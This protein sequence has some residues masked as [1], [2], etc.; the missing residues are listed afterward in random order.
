M[1]EPKCAD[2]TSTQDDEI[3]RE[4]EFDWSSDEIEA[5]EDT[6]NLWERGVSI[7]LLLELLEE[8]QLENLTTREAVSKFVLPQTHDYECSLAGVMKHSFE[9]AVDFATH[10][11]IHPWD[12]NFG[13]LVRA[14]MS[15]D[16]A[17][18]SVNGPNFQAFFW[19]DVFA[20][21]LHNHFAGYNDS[22]RLWLHRDD[23]LQNVRSCI[24]IIPCTC[25]FMDPSPNPLVM[26]RSW[27]L[28]ECMQALLYSRQLIL[29]YCPEP[30]VRRMEPAVKDFKNAMKLFTPN[31]MASKTSFL[32]DKEWLLNAVIA[33][34]PSGVSWLNEHVGN[35]MLHWLAEEVMS[36]IALVGEQPPIATLH[37]LALLLETLGSVE[38][39]NIQFVRALDLSRDQLGM[40]HSLTLAISHDLACMQAKHLFMF[41]EAEQLLCEALDGREKI[42]GK[43]HDLTNET[44]LALARLLQA[45][46]RTEQAE[47]LFR[48]AVEC[49]LIEH[50]FE[51]RAT[52][53]AANLLALLLQEKGDLFEAQV[54]LT[55]TLN[56][57][58][59]ILGPKHI[60]VLVWRNN[61]AVLLQDSQ[62]LK[63]AESVFRKALTDSEQSL[64]PDHQQ[65]LNIVYNLGQCLWQQKKLRA[66]E[67]LFRRELAGC[68]A[69]YGPDHHDTMRSGRNLVEFLQAQDRYEEAKEFVELVRIEEG[70]E[71]DDDEEEEQGGGF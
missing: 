8:H 68:Q 19:I 62:D 4:N 24:E 52:L 2:E 49:C 67:M 14:L 32:Q 69:I 51:H 7:E 6:V 43:T 63:R 60:D 26:G 48:R 28:Y 47:K 50:G 66:A 54:L 36:E 59:E 5:I 13:R 37:D 45:Q 1:A 21:D 29:S 20:I 25:L 33:A 44:V 31:F 11:V 22:E 53:V 17:Y 23:L 12:A 46:S 35:V 30:G 39:A 65:T 3:E 58:V 18:R 10:Y 55:R 34:H 61:L 64:G 15:V 9:D 41:D 42:F 38:Q 16:S 71:E 57:G 40:C 56:S 70:D 27:C